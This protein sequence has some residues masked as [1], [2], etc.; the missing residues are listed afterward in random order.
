M[1]CSCTE[2]QVAAKKAGDSIAEY[3]SE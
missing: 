3:V 2:E 1:R